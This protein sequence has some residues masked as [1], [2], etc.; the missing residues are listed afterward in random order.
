MSM[1]EIRGSYDVPWLDIFV[2]E[3]IVSIANDYLGYGL[4][5]LIDCNIIHCDHRSTIILQDNK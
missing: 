4:L 1:F 2:V 3:F 5:I